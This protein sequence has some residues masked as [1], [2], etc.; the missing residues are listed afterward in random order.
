MDGSGAFTFTMDDESQFFNQVTEQDIFENSEVYMN[1]FVPDLTMKELLLSV[2]KMF[3]LYITI[4][5]EDDTNLIIETRDEYYA[6]GTIRDWSK[7]L[8]R[9]RPITIKPL[10]LL[11]AK[12][13][14]YT[15]EEDED[16]YN[17]RY[18]EARGYAYGR[19]KREIDNDFLNNTNDVTVSFSPTPLANDDVTNRII[20][21]I[22]DADSDSGI[23]PTDINARVLYFQG[24]LASTPAWVFRYN[25]GN[26]S[27]IKLSYPYAGHLDNPLTPTLD[28]NFGIPNE[29]YYSANGY[30][31]TLQYTNAN[32]FNVYHRAYI[33]EI[34]NKD[35]KVM[36]G[37]F[38]LTPFDIQKLDFR[39]QILID[40]S[41]W[42]LNKVSDYN[43]FKEELTK[44]ELIKVIDIVPQ[45]FETFNIGVEG[46]A[47]DESYPINDKNSKLNR[48][49][50]KSLSG[51]VNGKLNRIDPTATAFKVIGDGN[52]IGANSK[53]VTILGNNN[54]VFAGVSNVVIINSHNQQVAEDNITIIDGQRT[55]R[56][57]DATANITAQDRQFIL[58]DATSG[59]FTVTLPKI[60]DATNM[61][62]N[63]KKVDS[64]LNAITI[65]PNSVSATIDGS[66]TITLNTQ[67]DAVDLYSDG[68]NWFI[69]SSH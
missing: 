23:K 10:G 61:W 32:L 12:D 17:N 3:N 25:G 19:R 22:Y 55:W 62:V 36:T 42:R 6:G 65:D 44:V 18:Q 41:Y 50:F 1:N 51:M 5:P 4:N 39:D 38:Y 9:N 26:T 64:T 7:K 24:S 13:Y 40:N 57:V 31:G 37:E 63:V 58:A 28:L 2:F 46:A 45:K 47:G 43:P 15:Y 14:I 34:T 56:Y 30:T 67:Y 35:S 16:Y 27:D 29:L 8:A 66:A 33:D 20:A 60:K 52:F 48:N 21:K 11:T 68:S 59:A 53:N 49:Q 69:R 54:E